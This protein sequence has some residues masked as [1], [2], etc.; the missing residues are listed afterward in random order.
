MTKNVR[1]IIQGYPEM[2]MDNMKTDADVSDDII[3]NV[4]ADSDMRCTARCRK[5]KQQCFLPKNHHLPPMNK[6]CHWFTPKGKLSSASIEKLLG[7]LTAGKIRSLAGLDNT[8][9]EKGTENFLQ[10]KAIV[11]TLTEVG[12]FG[13]GGNVNAEKLIERIDKMEEFHKVNFAKHLGNGK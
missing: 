11:H 9:V 4:I 2:S 3:D 7:Q 1:K 8:D 12:M 13:F 5:T 6:A 10:M